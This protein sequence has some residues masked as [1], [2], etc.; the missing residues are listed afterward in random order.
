MLL[1]LKPRTLKYD[2]ADCVT[3]CREKF[4]NKV[5]LASK[6]HHSAKKNFRRGGPAD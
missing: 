5:R 3:E 6:K 4:Y 1:Q 2:N